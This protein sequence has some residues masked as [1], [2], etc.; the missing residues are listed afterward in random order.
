MLSSHGTVTMGTMLALWLVCH[1]QSG[2]ILVKI[3]YC[4]KISQAVILRHHYQ[5]N[6]SYEF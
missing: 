1:Y 6:V 3:N 4:G 2:L 5:K